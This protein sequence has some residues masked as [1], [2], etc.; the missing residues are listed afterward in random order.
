MSRI[1]HTREVLRAA[2]HKRVQG[3]AQRA[4][5]DK[6]MQ[7]QTLK[8][9]VKYRARHVVRS[10]VGLLAEEA[11]LLS[12]SI[13]RLANGVGDVPDSATNQELNAAAHTCFTEAYVIARCALVVARIGGV[14][15][16]SA[17]EPESSNKKS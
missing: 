1:R 15:I 9:A 3:R 14:L 16:A 10:A 5:A 2:V 11:D 7:E 17:E 13:E 8:E 12:H 4:E 6:L